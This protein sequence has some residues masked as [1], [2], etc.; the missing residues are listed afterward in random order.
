MVRS[1]GM[2]R[3]LNYFILV[4][5]IVSTF[6]L[7]INSVT[8]VSAA[9]VYPYKGM[10]TSGTLVVHNKANL[11]ST[12]SET[13]I[14]FGT[15]IDVLEKVEYSKGKYVLKIKYDGEKIGYV[16]TKYVDNLDANTL[17]ESI[18]GI[19]TYGDYCNTL[20][21]KGFDKS[22]CPYLYYLHSKYPNWNFT[23]DKVGESLDKSSTSQQGSGVLPTDN[24]N[25][26]YSS[27]PIEGGY[28]YVKAS[29]IASIMDPRN[30]L[31]E[32]RIFQFLDLEDSS[33][34][35]SDDTL[36]EISGSN[37]LSK[38]FNEFKEAAK[39]NNVNI[40]HIMSRSRQEGANDSSYSSV[41]GLYTTNTDWNHTSQQ[42]YSLDG[43][44]NF[45][46][47]NAYASGWYKYTVQR[48]LAYAA[49][50]LGDNSCINVT[51]NM[52]EDP[53]S[54]KIAVYT[55]TNLNSEGK[56]CGVL[57]YQRP[58]NTPAKAIS[59]GADFIASA[60][61]RQGQDNL[62]FQ[63]FNVSSYSKTDIHSHQ[64]MTNLEAPVSE[65]KIIYSAYKNSGLLNS[66][67]NFVI[68]VYDN[69]PDTVYQP[70]NKSSNNRLSNITINDK[71]FEVFDADVVEYEYN[72]VTKDNSF[73]V[74]AKTEDNTASL[75]GTGDYTFVDGKVQVKIV[76][77]AEDGSIN[78]YV[79]NIKKVVPEEVVKVS[80]I[81]SKMGVKVNDSF[82]YG[83]SPD[84]AITT[85][86]NTVTKNKGEAK[87][88]DSAG[89][90]KSSG[91]FA[92]G[93]KITIFGTSEEKT[94]TIAVRGDANG[95]GQITSVDMLRIQK[96]INGYL[97]LK[98][99]QYY[100]ADANEDAGITSVDML[101]VQKHIN[102]YSKM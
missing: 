39:T 38:Y 33:E 49:G 66:N 60:Y 58:W 30:S 21:G 73:K 96:H 83:I 62:Y 24:Q 23:P 74:G 88:V 91:S 101:K 51:G 82:I 17:T 59:G 89:K 10:I 84:T 3:L 69:M 45:Y 13:E 85:L 57:S 43:Y 36:K 56:A 99:E 54:P 61:I 65:A 64:Y 90:V 98:N 12:S 5:C 70:V 87:V 52:T 75:T 22:Y 63:K 92:T 71:N 7:T 79:L 94:F 20:V 86:V 68:P 55:E 8:M 32:D 72:L 67:F 28:Y 102:G 37:N 47:I 44:Y 46:N 16:S 27:K 93:D 77:T 14:A 35:Y 40:V 11:S 9:E 76:V 19:E 100:A 78:T 31:F 41:T 34:I 80:D 1:D 29:V 48:G 18:E 97:T 81:T 50:Y 26:W 2:K 95:D 6:L 53:L 15:V 42:G 25:Y 4:L